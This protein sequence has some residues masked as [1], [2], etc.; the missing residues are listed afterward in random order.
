MKEAVFCFADERNP[1]VHATYS[2]SDNANNKVLRTIFR[3]RFTLTQRR[4]GRKPGGV[5]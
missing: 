1:E 3:K 5:A 2:V 4:R